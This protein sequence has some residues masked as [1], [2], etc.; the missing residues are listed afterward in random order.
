M[1]QSTAERSG[2]YVVAWRFG[3]W[4]VQHEDQDKG[5]FNDQDEAVRFA[6]TLARRQA[7]SGRVG[8][9]VVQSEI[10]EMHCF[11]PPNAE[12]AAP[13]QPPQQPPRLRVVWGAK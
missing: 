13:P 6:C 3:R 7:R 9:V 10:H 12:F 1:M 4:R 8:V 2:K 11:T 5:A